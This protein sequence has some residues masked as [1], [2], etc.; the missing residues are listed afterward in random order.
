MFMM[1][2]MLTFLHP[3]LMPIAGTPT[4]T[5][6]KL[7]AKE[8]YIDVHV[9]PSTCGE[10]AMGT[11]ALSCQWPSTSFQL[12]AHPGPVPIHATGTNAAT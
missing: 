5:S 10:G 4:N 6:L 11:S 3:H 9:I 8:I 2:T 7:P 1:S 12:P